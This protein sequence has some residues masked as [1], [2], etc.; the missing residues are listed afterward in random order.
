VINTTGI[1]NKALVA[2]KKYKIKNPKK[3][4]PRHNKKKNKGPK[5][6][7]L[8]SAPNGEK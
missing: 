2:Q 6:T 4:H 5:P 8:T 1:S 3:Q 7:Q